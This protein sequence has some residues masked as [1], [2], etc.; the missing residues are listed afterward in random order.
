MQAGKGHCPC[1]LV[2]EQSPLNR[3][4][5][6]YS[7]QLSYGRTMMIG[8]NNRGSTPKE[9]LFIQARLFFRQLVDILLDRLIVS[10]RIGKWSLGHDSQLEI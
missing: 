3:F 4:V 1:L 5:V 10:G 2:F 7:I 9:C 8:K 6:K